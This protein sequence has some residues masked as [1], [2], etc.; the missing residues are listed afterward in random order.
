MTFRGGGEEV[1]KMVSYSTCLFVYLRAT[2]NFQFSCFYLS[3]AGIA[4][5]YYIFGSVDQPEGLIYAQQTLSTNLLQLS[6]CDFDGSVVKGKACS[7]S[8][9][10]MG[11]LSSLR[12]PFSVR[13]FVFHS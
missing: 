10:R 11:H 1:G 7:Q 8:I 4:Y 3:Y 13:D 2:L 5:L 9:K 12:V 6:A